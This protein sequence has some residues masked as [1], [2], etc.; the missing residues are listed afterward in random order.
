MAVAWGY[1]SIAAAMAVETCNSDGAAAYFS[2]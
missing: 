2:A 1:S